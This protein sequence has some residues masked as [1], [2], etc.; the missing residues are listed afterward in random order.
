MDE[1]SIHLFSQYNHHATIEAKAYE[2]FLEGET[3]G[4][5]WV[6][7]KMNDPLAPHAPLVM[8]RLIADDND[9]HGELTTA[10]GVN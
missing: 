1:T 8:F 3:D 7:M 2:D 5:H 10:W 4:R 9:I 6:V